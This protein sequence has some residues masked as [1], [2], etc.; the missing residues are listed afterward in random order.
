MLNDLAEAMKALD[1]KKCFALCGFC[2]LFGL[3]AF[4]VFA[5]CLVLCPVFSL[6]SGTVKPVL[7]PAFT[8]GPIHDY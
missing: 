3:F 2:L 1:G 8:V 4:S 6:P 5:F 7:T